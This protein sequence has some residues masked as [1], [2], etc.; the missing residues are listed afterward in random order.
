MNDAAELFNNE[1][2]NIVKDCIRYCF[3]SRG[4]EF[5]LKK[6]EELSQVKAEAIK[7]K[8]EAIEIGDEDSANAMLRA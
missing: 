2:N 4:V 5:Q 8:N 6:S 3:L 7:L 1:L